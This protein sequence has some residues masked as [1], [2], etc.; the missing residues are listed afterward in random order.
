M[1]FTFQISLMIKFIVYFH[2][3]LAITSSWEPEA[4]NEEKMTDC[5]VKRT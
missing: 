3:F 2:E 1:F 4:L 5:V